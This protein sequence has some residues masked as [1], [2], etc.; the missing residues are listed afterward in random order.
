[1]IGLADIAWI[2]IAV[3]AAITLVLL[4]AI[5]FFVGLGYLQRRLHDGPGKDA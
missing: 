3:G 1:M 2:A 5:A 4:L